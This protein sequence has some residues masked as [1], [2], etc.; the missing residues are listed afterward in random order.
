MV[1]N[2]LTLSCSVLHAWQNA[3][4]F[5]NAAAPSVNTKGDAPWK[6]YCRTSLHRALHWGHL[7]AAALL[8]EAGASLS[9]QDDKV[10]S[11]LRHISGVHLS[12]H[13]NR[14]GQCKELGKDIA[15]WCPLLRGL[16]V[17]EGTLM[18]Q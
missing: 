16:W 9:V 4:C 15:H 5:T 13:N 3:L 1:G 8:L 6:C 17:P 7:Q 12:C 18:Q 11:L 14:P 2:S 10:S